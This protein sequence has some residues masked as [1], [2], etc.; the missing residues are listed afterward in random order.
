MEW[1]TH[2]RAL[3][4][5]WTK[6]YRDDALTEMN[7]VK[8]SLG[9]DR[10]TLSRRYLKDGFRLRRPASNVEAATLYMDQYWH[11]CVLDA[12]RQ[13]VKSGRVFMKNKFRAQYRYVPLF[14]VLDM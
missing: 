11:W 4:E 10:I 12:C 7:I 5:Y 2:L 1:V 3:V 8:E 9:E 14:F 13:I 6:R